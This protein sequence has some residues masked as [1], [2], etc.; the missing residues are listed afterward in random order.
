M[1]PAI[2]AALLGAIAGSLIHRSW[3]RRELKREK[4]WLEGE[5][6]LAK[7]AKA[8]AAK[9]QQELAD[10]PTPPRGPYLAWSA[11][12]KNP[13]STACGLDVD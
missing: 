10:I 12:Q 9:L 4:S 6:R 5:I 1:H 3:T 7:Q 13:E 8:R 11:F 2:P